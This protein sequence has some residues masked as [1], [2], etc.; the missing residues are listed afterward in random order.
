M[1]SMSEEGLFH[2]PE[3]LVV[4]GD[5]EA[6]FAALERGEFALGW[7]L[8]CAAMKKR[9]LKFGEP[10]QGSEEYDASEE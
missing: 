2:E 4:E 8:A 9:V 1:S 6:W 3:P 5:Q 7:E 10:W